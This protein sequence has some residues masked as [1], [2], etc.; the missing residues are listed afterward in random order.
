MID[1]LSRQLEAAKLSAQQAEQEVDSARRQAAA[2]ANEQMQQQ[3]QRIQSANTEQT[4]RDREAASAI[5]AD[6]QA[7]LK[8]KEVAEQKVAKLESDLNK[9]LQALDM[10]VER[11]HVAEEVCVSL[12]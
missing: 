10:A 3:Q 9:Q 6:L 8:A 11:A 4:Q 7:A 12:Y 2:W 5:K 1:E